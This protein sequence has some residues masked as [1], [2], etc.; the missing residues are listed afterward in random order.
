MLG[1]AK[2]FAVDLRSRA[3]RRLGR[4]VTG[5]STG[6][7]AGWQQAGHFWTDEKLMVRM[8]KRSSTFPI[9]PWRFLRM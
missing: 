7:G 8:S 2:P 4:R 6:G 1:S 3:T 9:G 5:G